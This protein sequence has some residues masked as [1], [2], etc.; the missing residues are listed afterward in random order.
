VQLGVHHAGG[1]VAPSAGQHQPR[2]A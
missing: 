1:A 2:L